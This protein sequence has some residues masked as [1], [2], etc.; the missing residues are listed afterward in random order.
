MRIE[1]KK[2]L[3]FYL[4]GS[5]SS[6]FGDVLLTTALA[7]FIMK[8]TH[9][10]KAFGEILALAFLPRM[11]LSLFA[12]AIVDRLNGKYVMIA[13]DLIRGLM[14]IVFL[15]IG[16]YTLG[17]IKILIISFAFSYGFPHCLTFKLLFF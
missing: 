7:I 1:N 4:F 9:S 10:P 13:L 2:N 3:L 15:I 14:L 6:V 16:N 8:T 12:G 17:G 5:N 11:L